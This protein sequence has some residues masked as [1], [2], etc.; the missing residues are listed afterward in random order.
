[1]RGFTAL[2]RHPRY[3]D[4]QQPQAPEHG[5]G[6]RPRPMRLLLAL[7]LVALDGLLSWSK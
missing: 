6:E 7:G 2:T 4:S 5:K 1:M 3:I